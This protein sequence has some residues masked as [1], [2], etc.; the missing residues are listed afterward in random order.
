M[1]TMSLNLSR[2]DVD[3]RKDPDGHHRV[4]R[5]YAKHGDQVKWKAPNCNIFITFPASRTPLLNGATEA[6]GRSP[7][8]AGIDPKASG[9]FVYLAMVQDKEGELHLVEGN[10]PPE[11]V[12]E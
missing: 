10:S 3:I 5:V 7:L 9:Y 8:S 1:G 6:S 12:I 4:M 2:T 11:M